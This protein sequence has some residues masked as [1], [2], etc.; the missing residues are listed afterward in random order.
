MIA[1]GS[2]PA[3]PQTVYEED[4]AFCYFLFDTLPYKGGG[5]HGGEKGTDVDNQ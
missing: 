1:G 5:E 3:L 4:L 2:P